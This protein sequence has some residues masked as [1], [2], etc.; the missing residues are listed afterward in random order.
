MLR[1]L[2]LISTLLAVS[3]IIQA[4][5]STYKIPL[6]K[7]TESIVSK[8]VKV[9]TKDGKTYDLVNYIIKE[10]VLTGKDQKGNQVVIPK[11]NIKTIDGKKPNKIIIITFITVF[12]AFF[13]FLYY[14]GEN[15][16]YPT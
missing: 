4:C 8:P 10:N 12:T 3:L 9:T 11:E 5:I 16:P 2:K 7:E 13:L 15:L 14:L 1:N 6:D